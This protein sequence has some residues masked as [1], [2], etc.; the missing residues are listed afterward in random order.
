MIECI[1]A[2][3]CVFL[4]FYTKDLTYLLAAGLFAI[5]ANI[6]ELTNKED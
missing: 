5:A 2:W 6:S 3:L 4:T 1:I